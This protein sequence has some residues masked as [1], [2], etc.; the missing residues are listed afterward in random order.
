MH[1]GHITTST[2]LCFPIT[3][4]RW[5]GLSLDA[6]TSHHHR[7]SSK[8]PHSKKL[9]WTISICLHKCDNFYERAFPFEILRGGRNGKKYKY[10]GVDQWKT[11]EGR[12]AKFSIP[13]PPQDLKK[14]SPKQ[15]DMICYGFLECI[16]V[17]GSEVM[18]ITRA[19]PDRRTW[20]LYLLT[21]KLTRAMRRLEAAL[22]A[23]YSGQVWINLLDRSTVRTWLGQ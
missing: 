22:K 16:V 4:F 23:S 1:K 14:N 3:I 11:C 19:S 9:Q 13:R 8:S 10:V 17:N 5:K 6:P 21:R 12:S 2:R 7:K 15:M 20:S 18:T